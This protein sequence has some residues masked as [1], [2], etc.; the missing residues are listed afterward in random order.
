MQD[1]VQYQINNGE[2]TVGTDS[3]LSTSF[4][5]STTPNLYRVRATAGSTVRVRV[6]SS[7][8]AGPSEFVTSNSLL[9]AGMLTT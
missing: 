1:E 7:N 9:V 5:K 4:I 6:R 8:F 3:V 2:W